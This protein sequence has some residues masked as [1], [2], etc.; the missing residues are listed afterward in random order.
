MNTERSGVPLEAWHQK[1]IVYKNGKASIILHENP[2]GTQV[3]YPAWVDDFGNTFDITHELM[4]VQ[5]E[6]GF[7]PHYLTADNKRF[8]VPKEI[9]DAMANYSQ[10]EDYYKL[11]DKEHKTEL[12]FYKKQME[13]WKRMYYAMAFVALGVLSA[14]F[15]EVILN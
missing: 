4:E 1:P 9:F 3:I 15:Y 14:L 7:E 6:T 2:D 13:Q 10:M 12:A 5:K 11:I 8:F